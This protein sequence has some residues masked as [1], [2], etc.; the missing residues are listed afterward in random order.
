[1]LVRYGQSFRGVKVHVAEQHG[2]KGVIIY[3]D[4]ED[5]GFVRGPVFPEGPGAPRTRSSAE[6]SSSSGTTRAIR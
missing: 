4:P 2:A 3:S 1:M 5:D 6:A